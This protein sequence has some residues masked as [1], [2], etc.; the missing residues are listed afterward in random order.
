MTQT[1]T[2][3]FLLQSFFFSFFIE[4]VWEEFG[5]KEDPQTKQCQV[6]IGIS[7]KPKLLP[8]FSGYQR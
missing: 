2:I 6:S 1:A 5:G 3:I 4:I 8:V 7:A